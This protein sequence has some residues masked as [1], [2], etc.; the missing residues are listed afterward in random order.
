MTA[1]GF[2]REVDDAVARALAEDLGVEAAALLA[3]SPTVL[4]RDVTTTALFDAAGRFTGAVNARQACVVCGVAAAQRAFTMLAEA[5]AL[6]GELR[7]TPL[8]AD[9]DEV[10][11][12]A[13][14]LWVEGPARVVL[15]AERTA[16]DFLMVLSGIATEARRWQR[17][18]GP[19]LKVYDTRKTCPGLRALSKHAVA[20]GGAHNHRTGLWDMVLI[21]DNHVARVG[22]VAEAVCRAKT[23]RPD[24]LVEAEAENLADAVAAVEAGADVVMLD[25]MDDDAVAAAVGAVR[26]VAASAGRSVE[27][28]VSG[29]V[30][31]ERLPRLAA[32]GVD[33]V[34]TSR[35]TLAPPIDFGLDE[36]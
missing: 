32:L 9:G 17:A 22:S 5:A 30:T 36:E 6:A 12:G 2:A 14:V 26:G 4:E 24:L 15:A 29:R 28:E 19:S 11:A 13:S 34:S 8:V 18:A 31:I 20:A 1:D 10:E 7:A 16:L 35:I 21:K 25:N 3:A 23:A 27:V 33:R